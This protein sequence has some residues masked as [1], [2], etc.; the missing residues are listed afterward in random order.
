MEHGVVS[1]E[2]CLCKERMNFGGV[3]DLALTHHGCFFLSSYSQ[4]FAI[5]FIL[6]ARKHYSVDVFTALYVVPLLFQ[7]L[8]AKLPDMDTESSRMACHYGIRFYRDAHGR[9]V[10]GLFGNEFYMSP[11][12]LPMDLQ[13]QLR[14]EAHYEEYPMKVLTESNVLEMTEVDPMIV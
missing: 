12:D 1:G 4:A 10:V 8:K 13:K 9:F 5:P 2:L 3:F 7:F 14:E 11:S 6:A